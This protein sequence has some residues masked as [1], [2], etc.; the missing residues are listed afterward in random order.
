MAV[1]ADLNRAR[2]EIAPAKGSAGYLSAWPRDIG[3]K[4]TGEVFEA[5]TGGLE[6]KFEVAKFL[7]VFEHSY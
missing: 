4:L 3:L 5:D 1:C 2:P 7:G 6:R